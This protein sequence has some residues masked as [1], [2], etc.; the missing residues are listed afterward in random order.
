MSE[1][2]RSDWNRRYLEGRYSPRPSPFSLLE[3]RIDR[4]PRGRALDVACG[5]GRNALFL[6]RHGYQVEAV[7]V[8]AEALRQGEEHARAEGLDV[9][10]TEADLDDYT[11]PEG[12]YAVVVNCFYLNRKLLPL[13]TS[14]LVEGGYIFVEQHLRT[15]LPVS[16]S[17]EW[18]LEPNELLHMLGGLRVLHYQEGIARDED[19]GRDRDIAVVRMVAC[20]G[21]GGF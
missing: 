13:L 11:P 4:L 9:D 15:P 12:R 14:A 3:Q 18:R 8:A 19:A 16:G 1:Q 7:D 6:A 17:R 21:S 20:N 2:E 5:T 10:W